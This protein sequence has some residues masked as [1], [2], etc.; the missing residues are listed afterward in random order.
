[1]PNTRATAALVLSAIA[2]V[3][4]LAALV[5]G[6]VA[7]TDRAADPPTK[8]DPQAYTVWL[9]DQALDRYQRDGIDATLAH[10][11]SPDGADGPWYV[12]IVDQQ[13]IVR[14]HQNPDLHGELLTGPQGTDVTGYE[15]GK[16]MA[17]A[18]EEGRWVTYVFANPQTGEQQRKHSWVIRRDGNLFGS[19]WYD[20]ASHT[21]P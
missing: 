20:Y 13:N 11:N 8:A 18:D 4:G 17:G 12:F 10:Y 16:A 15:F 9:V 14:G 1:M 3:V 7:L 2:T 5:V 19:G 21:L 6:I